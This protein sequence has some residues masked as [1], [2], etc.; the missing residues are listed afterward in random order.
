MGLWPNNK[1]TSLIQ[2]QCL[3]IKIKIQNEQEIKS[4]A[5]WLKNKNQNESKEIL[6]LTI[7]QPHGSMAAAILEGQ[8][9]LESKL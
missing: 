3:L 1:S 5:I 9:T 7:W 6:R 2:Y 4:I 8:V